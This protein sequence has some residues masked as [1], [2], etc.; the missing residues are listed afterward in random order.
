MKPAKNILS[1]TPHMLSV[2]VLVC[3]ATNTLSFAAAVDPMRAANRQA[4]RTL[5]DWRYATP[6]GAPVR[7][8]SALDI[9]GAA[10]ADVH[11]TDLL[12]V[13]AGFALDRHDTPALRASL[14]RL[15][16]AGTT[17]AGIDGGPWLMAAAGLLD[18]EVA[19]THWEDLAKFASRFPDVTTVADRFRISGARLTCGGALP[20][21][22]M[23]LHII[24]A[25]YGAGLAAQVAGAFIHDS[26]A[27][28][29]RPQSP[30]RADPRHNRLTSEA[31]AL[32]EHTIDTP[33][34]IPDIAQRVSTTPR[35]LEAQFNARL[36]HSP[37]A[38]YLSL[39]LTEALRLVTQTDLPLIDV[40]LATGFSSAASF[41][42]AFRKAHGTSAR[43]LRSG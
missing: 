25:R 33:L 3:D 6:T 11:H 21:I 5:F 8:T 36:G 18:Q 19:T 30:A 43:A 32:M 16:K 23:M 42:R 35:R 15:A 38:H 9:P 7:L 14:R 27:D 2:T 41:A 24:S 20:A 34:S 17:I 29:A 37:K 31:S 40:A 22:D 13:L 1:P 28:P 39:R 4:G 10:I 26:P 12:I